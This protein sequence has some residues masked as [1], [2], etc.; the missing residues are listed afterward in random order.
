M[1]PKISDVVKSIRCEVTTFLVENKL[2][3]SY[4]SPLFAQVQ[5]D[6]K[7]GLDHLVAD[8][9]ATI[10]Q[11]P[12]LDIDSRQLGFLNVDLQNIDTLS[13][14]LGYTAREAVARL[15]GRTQSIWR[16]RSDAA[17]AGR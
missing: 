1:G 9:I 11:F 3:S 10:R 8:R 16:V 17:S 4:V 2:R 14:T 5:A 6:T 13:M 15:E 7:R 12:Y